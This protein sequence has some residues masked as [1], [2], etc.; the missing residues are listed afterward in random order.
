MFGTL[1]VEF[2]LTMVLFISLFILN[3][4]I[5]KIPVK[6]NDKQIV[7]ISLVVGSVNY[8][9]KF[10]VNSPF[11]MLYQVIVTI[12]MLIIVRRYPL[13]YSFIV[14]VTGSLAVSL[15]DTIVTV[16]SI[17][18]FS[19][20]ELLGKNPI[21][22]AI[23]H[24]ITSVLCLLVAYVLHKKNRGFSFVNRRFSGKHSLKTINFIWAFLLLCGLMALQFTNKFDDDSFHL[25]I[26]IFVGAS[27]AASI[28]YAYIQNKKVLKD[29]NWKG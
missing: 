18:T 22:F 5:F 14:T 11:F 24:L 2:I 16:V 4:I 13:L 8:Y 15:I 7:L 23:A 3:F 19:S 29:R 25:Y 21:H 12:I 1:L 17:R 9:F 6:D 27:L 10:I 26:I 20:I 28:I